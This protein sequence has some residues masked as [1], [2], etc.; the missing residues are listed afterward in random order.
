[1]ELVSVIVP[2]YKVENYLERCVHSIQNQT[3]K[4]LEIILVDD[5]SPDNCGKIC[6]EFA[7]NDKRIRVIHKINGGLSEARNFGI[8]VAEGKYIV[9]VDSD[10]WID[11][12]MIEL[13]L[14]I[15]EMHNADIVECSYRNVYKDK[16]IEETYCRGEI[17]IGDSVFALKG[18]LDW[19]YFKPV[20]WNKL[21][22]REVLGDIRYPK[23]KLHE[24]EFTTYK[25][26]YNAKK[27]AYVDVSKYN[28][29]RTR[30]DSITGKKFQASNLDACWAFR[31]RVDFFENHNINQLQEKMNNI[32][33]WYVAE[34][35]YKCYCYD[36]KDKK[37]DELLSQIK[38]DILY[39]GN[40]K[41]KDEY[42]NDLRM[43][44]K[45]GIKYYG[46]YRQQR[47]NE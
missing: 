2:V 12:D 26:F 39:F 43:I 8:D 44:N 1:M 18:M 42:L 36:I 21:Y 31:E 20:A 32:Y 45:N 27:M 22:K 33:C 5:G 34:S 46:K 15:R 14:R 25:Y 4:H 16:I 29:D 17:V 40:K 3:Y 7:E 19:K 35:I 30:E 13:L 47:I 38:R 24:D 6:D 41:V 28:Y 9:F 37:V 11:P 23:G 10:D